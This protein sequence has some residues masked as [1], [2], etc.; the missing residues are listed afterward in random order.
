MFLHLRSVSQKL[1]AVNKMLFLTKSNHWAYE[2]ELRMLA[3]P[4]GATVKKRGNDGFDILLFKFPP[5]LLKEII[6]G[7]LMELPLRQKIS[8]I[9]QR[10]CPQ[11][12]L[13]EAQLS[14]HDFDLEIVPYRKHN[15]KL[16]EMKPPFKFA[17]CINNADYPASLDLYKIYRVLP[18]ADATTDGDIRVVDESGEDYFYPAEYFVFVDLPRS[19]EE[20]L[21]RAA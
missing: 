17:V 1:E 20:S 12:Q 21:L 16:Q 13:F 8:D 19:V 2:E 10:N 9:V 18:D 15:L 7:H 3:K 4:E 5:E 6:F 11:V 14:E